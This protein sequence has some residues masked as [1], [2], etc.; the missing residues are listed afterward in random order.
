M[1]GVLV[2]GKDTRFK[3][4]V[5]NSGTPWTV[6]VKTW[7]IEEDGEIVKDDVNGETRSRAQKIT[8]G[9]KF[10][11]D[12]YE[13]GSSQILANCIATQAAIDANQ[14]APQFGSG[15]LFTYNDGTKAAFTLGT[16]T[17]GPF[18]ATDSGRK[19]RFM[20]SLSGFAQTFAQVQAA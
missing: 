1:A 13:D 19:Q 18:K 2:S 3:V 16:A 20:H 12:C 7:S 17:L 10:T 9:Y 4:Y 6:T 15:V 8:D 14:P 5:G 11:F